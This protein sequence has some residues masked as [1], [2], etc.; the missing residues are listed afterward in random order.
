MMTLNRRN[1]TKLLGA[2][3][4]ATVA[5][6]LLGTTPAARADNDNGNWNKNGNCGNS[7]DN[8]NCRNW[9]GN[10]N[11]HG[12]DNGNWNHNQ[13][14]GGYGAPPPVYYYSAPR[15][16]VVPPSIHIGVY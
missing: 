9:H 16:Y 7:R 3:A 14:H 12:N 1:W 4:M 8:G 15:V 11:G 13:Y 10:G 2:A 5:I 6:G